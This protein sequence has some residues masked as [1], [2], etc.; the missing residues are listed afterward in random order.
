[1]DLAGVALKELLIV[2][3]CV[4]IASALPARNRWGPVFYGFLIPILV[5]AL[6]VTA[7]MQD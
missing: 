3:P 5:G 4:L 6:M 2:V 1:M 7:R